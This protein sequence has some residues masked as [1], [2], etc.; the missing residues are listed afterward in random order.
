MTV[1]DGTAIDVR[2]VSGTESYRSLVGGHPTRIHGRDRYACS[3]C[4]KAGIGSI[5][6]CALETIHTVSLATRVQEYVENGVQFHGF[7]RCKSTFSSP[8]SNVSG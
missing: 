3:A 1:D 7:T 8:G 6:P 4:F 2:Q 5:R